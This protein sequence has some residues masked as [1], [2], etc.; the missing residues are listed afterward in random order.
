MDKEFVYAIIIGLQVET[1]VSSVIEGIIKPKIRKEK[2]DYKKVY[3]D[4]IIGLII[5]GSIYTIKK[6]LK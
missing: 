4:V 2:E 3:E 6:F 5:I 1:I